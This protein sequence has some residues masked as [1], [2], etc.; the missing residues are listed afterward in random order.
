MVSAGRRLHVERRCRS[1][2]VDRR[3]VRQPRAAAGLEA[4]A[5]DRHGG[6]HPGEP[7]RIARGPCVTANPSGAAG[8]PVQPTVTETSFD[9]AL[10]PPA[11]PPGRG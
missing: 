5:A 1:G 6:R 2:Q 10:V 11:Q 3:Q 7:Y 8:G 9:G 4:E